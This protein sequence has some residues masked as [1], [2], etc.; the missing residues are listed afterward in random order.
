M[1]R[2]VL[3]TAALRASGKSIVGP[4]LAAGDVYVC[5]INADALNSTASA[6]KGLKTGLRN[7]CERG[8]VETMVAEAAKRLGGIDVLVN[9]AGS[10]RTA[11]VRD[12]DPDQW[13][14]VLKVNLTG[15]Q[16]DEEQHSPTSCPPAM[17][18]HVFRRRPVRP[19]NRSPYA[20]TKWGLKCFAKALSMDPNGVHLIA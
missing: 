12:I 20:T 10:G 1:Y 14:Q 9:D 13:E 15:V 2:N 3:V 6:L 18:L 8:Q 11:A 4:S 7:I 16:R 17:A 19:P 5:D